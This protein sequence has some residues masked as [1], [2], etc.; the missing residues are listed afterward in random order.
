[1]KCLPYSVTA[2]GAITFDRVVSLVIFGP[3]HHVLESMTQGDVLHLSHTHKR[4]P[5]SNLLQKELLHQ[6]FSQFQRIVLSTIMRIYLE[7][8]GYP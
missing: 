5:L 6:L 8:I 2:K 7:H 4:F 1:M 3:V